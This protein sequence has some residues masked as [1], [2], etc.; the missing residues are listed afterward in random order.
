MTSVMATKLVLPLIASASRGCSLQRIMTRL[1][2]SDTILFGRAPFV[3]TSLLRGLKEKTARRRKSRT[4]GREGCL[5]SR[6]TAS[7][8]FSELSQAVDEGHLANSLP[9]FFD[10]A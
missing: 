1:L 7:S 3:V 6:V 4:S 10:S 5:P 2:I 9:T 8:H